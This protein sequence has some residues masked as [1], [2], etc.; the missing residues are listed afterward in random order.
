[1]TATT[2]N[3]HHEL[4]GL[5]AFEDQHQKEIREHARNSLALGL[6]LLGIPDEEKT[7]EPEED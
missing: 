1:M 5:T 6:L 2:L 7:E 3:T 4:I